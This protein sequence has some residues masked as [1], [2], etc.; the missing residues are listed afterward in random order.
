MTDSSDYKKNTLALRPAN[1]EGKGLRGFLKD[2]DEVAPRGVVAKPQ[3]QIL[4]EFF[5]SMLVLSAR[6]SHKPAVGVANY[7]YFIDGHWSLSLIAP[8]QWSKA[9][10]QAFAGVCSLQH[11]RTWTIRLAETWDDKKPVVD[12]IRR[13]YDAFAA[14]L[15]Q[16]GTLEDILPFHVGNL[17]YY[18]R[19]NANALGNS[20]RATM[21]L[22]DQRD[23]PTREWAP[24][25]PNFQ[26]M[27]D[28]DEN[29]TES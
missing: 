12:A 11:D 9:R 19:L 24:A 10:Q 3:P 29:S 14:T 16:D 18:Q 15:D 6:F 20:I 8:D 23:I 13:A 21:T 26:D 1:P 22:G 27:V 2:A 4:A 17:P 28:R 5:T 7:L 25:L